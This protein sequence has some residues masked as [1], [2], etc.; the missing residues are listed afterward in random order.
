MDVTSE[1]IFGAVVNDPSAP[2]PLPGA[3]ALFAGAAALG[4][5]LVKRR[6]SA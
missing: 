5:R 2:V 1:T 3:M 6:R 4:G